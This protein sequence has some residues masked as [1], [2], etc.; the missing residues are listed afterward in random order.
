[1]ADDC[2]GLEWFCPDVVAPTA[3]KDFEGGPIVNRREFSQPHH[4][5]VAVLALAG[6]VLGGMGCL[7]FH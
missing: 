1:M 7:N 2:D 4:L 6:A 3:T 5:N